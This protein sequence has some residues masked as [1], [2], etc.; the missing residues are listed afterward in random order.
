MDEQAGKN[1]ANLDIEKTDQGTDPQDNADAG[2]GKEDLDSPEAGAANAMSTDPGS[3]PDEQA[4]VDAAASQAVEFFDQLGSGPGE[5]DEDAA[6]AGMPDKDGIPGT[7][8]SMAVMEQWLEQIEGDPAYLLLNQFRIEEQQA[9]QREGR[10]LL[11]T[12]PW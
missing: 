9:M 2:G 1:N 12:R 7:G 11:E 5:I 6:Q 4:E 10:Q 8:V 3:L